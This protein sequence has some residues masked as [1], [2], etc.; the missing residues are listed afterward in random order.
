VVTCAWCG[1]T[2]GPAPD[3]APIPA[4][5]PDVQSPGAPPTDA[6]PSGVDAATSASSERPAADAAP[7]ERLATSAPP[8]WSRQI[9]E[10]GEEWLCERC[11][12]D[13]LRAIEARLDAAW[14]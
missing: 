2:A 14:W 5:P 6:P 8:T 3:A 12:R 7:P 9:T 13:N 4:P 11:T 10:R 1:A